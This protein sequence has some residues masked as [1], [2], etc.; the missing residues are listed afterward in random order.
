MITWTVA[1]ILIATERRS[2]TANAGRR[3]ASRAGR[4]NP[5]RNALTASTDRVSQACASAGS[6]TFSCATALLC[7]VNSAPQ[8]SAPT[9][10][11]PADH[12]NAVV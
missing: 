2:C 7:L 10:K 6:P 12:Q 11:M 9:P 4:G 1:A 3:Q 5:A 8:T